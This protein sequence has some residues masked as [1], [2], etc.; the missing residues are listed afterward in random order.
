REKIRHSLKCSIFCIT[1]I[2]FCLIFLGILVS[3]SNQTAFYALC[4]FVL[5]FAMLYYTW[6]REVSGSQEGHIEVKGMKFGDLQLG[7][8][9]IQ[10]S[11]REA[12]HVDDTSTTYYRARVR[13][14]I[15]GCL[16]YL[17]EQARPLMAPGL[18]EGSLFSLGL[19]LLALTFAFNWI[20]WAFLA[21]GALSIVIA[22]VVGSTGKKERDF[23]KLTEFDTGFY[24][25][26]EEWFQ[27][28][29]H[30]HEAG[31]VTRDLHRRR[32]SCTNKALIA[33]LI[34]H[35]VFGHGTRLWPAVS[36]FICLALFGCY[37]FALP[38]AIEPTTPIRLS[39]T[40]RADAVLAIDENIRKPD[41]GDPQDLR[42]TRQ[43]LLNR[44]KVLTDGM[45]Q[46]QQTSMASAG[47]LAILKEEQA[48]YA[49]GFGP[50]LRALLPFATFSLGDTFRYSNR[51]VPAPPGP[52]GAAFISP[53]GRGFTFAEVAALMT[54]AGWLLIPI[55]LIKLVAQ[56]RRLDSKDFEI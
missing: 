56:M 25:H 41:G 43:A 11:T 7:C 35:L 28:R 13:K 49:S 22:A 37:T 40:A 15:S 34:P 3:L 39:S 19:A 17:K 48:L 55:F 44:R 24:C 20:M 6:L 9:S 53:F 45:R 42:L 47:E 5:L 18:F 26:V 2:A 46:S 12:V 51:E 10:W 29:G 36:F 33:D 32:M 4:G 54:L 21:G 1:I 50:T 27:G 30:P 14:L 23:L 8:G 52:L 31:A 38:G 16:Q